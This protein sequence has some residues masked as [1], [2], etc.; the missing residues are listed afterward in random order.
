MVPDVVSADSDE[1]S[2]DFGVPD[3]QAIEWRCVQNA[4]EF[5]TEILVKCRFTGDNVLGFDGT[6]WKITITHLTVEHHK[7]F[8]YV[9]MKWVGLNHVNLDFMTGLSS[10]MCI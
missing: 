1:V 10:K 7:I 2:L 4:L 9:P 3:W 6:Q 5:I 8:I